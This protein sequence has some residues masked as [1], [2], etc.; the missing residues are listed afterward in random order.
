LS[1]SHLDL[2][3]DNFDLAHLV[4]TISTGTNTSSFGTIYY[5]QQES[6]K[7]WFLKPLGLGLW[8]TTVIVTILLVAGWFILALQEPETF[9]TY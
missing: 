5:V 7:Q 9:D 3:V 6:L 4:L 1:S 2:V 8:I